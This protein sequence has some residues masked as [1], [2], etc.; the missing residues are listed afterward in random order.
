[1]KRQIKETSIQGKRGAQRVTTYGYDTE[2]DG[3]DV[4][5]VAETNEFT[6]IHRK[7]GLSLSVYFT[8]PTKA[9]KFA[10]NYLHGFNFTQ[11]VDELIEDGKLGKCVY[12]ASIREDI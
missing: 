10:S 4:I 5:M 2:F 7:S 6:L 3:L 1:M 8:T 9:L 11:D 12:N